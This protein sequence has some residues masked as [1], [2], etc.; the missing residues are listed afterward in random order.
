MV[1]NK[2]EMDYRQIPKDY[3]NLNIP[4]S[5]GRYVS[6]FMPEQ[7]VQITQYMED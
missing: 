7:N 1:V 4:N 2:Y 3:L 5:R 6:I